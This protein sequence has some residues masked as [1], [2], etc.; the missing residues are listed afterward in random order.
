M[1]GIC[2]GQ[3]MINVYFGGTLIQHLPCA[4]SHSRSPDG[5]DRVHQEKVKPQCW[6]S[7][8]YGKCFAHNSCHDQS[9]DGSVI[10]WIDVLS[11]YDFR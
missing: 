5:Q 4:A 2:R 3:Q 7:G 8:I 1:L 6:L 11:F 9:G 10:G